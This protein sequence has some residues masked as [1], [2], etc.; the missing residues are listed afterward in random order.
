L[1]VASLR[2]PQADR[3][4]AS[5]ERRSVKAIG[6]NDVDSDS[7]NPNF[8][9]EGADSGRSRLFG[10]F[11]ARNERAPKAQDVLRGYVGR[12]RV[13]EAEAS[14]A[15]ASGA[16][17]FDSERSDRPAKLVLRRDRQRLERETVRTCH[18]F[19]TCEAIRTSSI[20]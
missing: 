19:F 14:R 13:A 9:A 2:P 3:R 18:I 10:G 8:D 5:Q 20:R 12:A 6:L 7:Y 15:A 11:A 1:G 4:S 17:Q 16:R